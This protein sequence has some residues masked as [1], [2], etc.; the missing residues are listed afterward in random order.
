MT[1]ESAHKEW[2]YPPITHSMHPQKFI[3]I[4]QKYATDPNFPYKDECIR[5]ILRAP[6]MVRYALWWAQNVGY[7]MD[8]IFNYVLENGSLYDHIDWY[9]IINY[10]N[11][12]MI[13]VKLI[14]DHNIEKFIDNF[15]WTTGNSKYDLSDFYSDLPREYQLGIVI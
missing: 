14:E 15:R 13:K 1:N 12:Y 9:R 6:D 10:S 11:N 2:N 5:Y 8:T 4:V 3:K 7:D